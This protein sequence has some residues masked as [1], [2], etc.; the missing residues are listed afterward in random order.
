MYFAFCS[1][2]LQSAFPRVRVRVNFGVCSGTID[3]PCLACELAGTHEV[4][5]VQFNNSK[6]NSVTNPKPNPCPNPRRL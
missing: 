2:I 6:P 1:H 4:Y 5:G 3:S